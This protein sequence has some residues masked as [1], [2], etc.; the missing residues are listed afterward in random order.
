MEQPFSGSPAGLGAYTGPWET[1]QVVHL[2]KRT[3]FGAS[4]AD[5]NYF[6]G[7]SM[8]QAVDELLQPGAAP[9]TKP[10]N[11]YGTDPTGVAEWQTWIDQGLL[12]TDEEM[13]MN[14][15]G[16]L[17]A[18]WTGQMLGQGR[19][20]HEKMTLFWHN[21]FAM[22][23]TQHFG[24]IPA[25]LWYNQYLTLRKYALGSF[26]DLVR[27]ITLDPAMLIFL[28][29]STNF[30]TSPN[31][32]Y[33]RELQELYTIGK[34]SGSQYTQDDVV[35]AT[36]VLTGHT[37]DA[38]YKYIFLAG[39]H[40][41]KNKT[42]SAFYGNAIVTGRSGTPGASELDEMLAMLFAT[43]ESAK[44]ICR[45]LYNYFVYYK[46]DDMIETNV[47]DPLATIFRQS[48]YNISSVLS[49]LFKSQHFYDLV[50][51]GACIIKSPLDLLVGLCREYKVSIPDASNVAGQY[52]CWSMLSER[53]SILQQ[54]IMAI[55]LVAGWDAYRQSP[56]YHELWI[57]S[58]TY[59]GR[60]FYTDLLITTGDMMDGA[61]LQI[62]P[63]A[64]AKLLPSPHDP[65]LLI[66]DSLSV[67]I[68]PPMSENA[69]ALLKQSIL[70]GNLTN[71]LYWT[72]AWLG[73]IGDPTNMSA[74]SAVHGKLT[75]LYKYLM[76]L[77]EYHLS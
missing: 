73:Y 6:K 7:L 25:Q 26:T 67:L 29:G 10:L 54:E 59:T 72:N 50:N 43:Q 64:F 77:P 39:E 3:M 58:V 30:K 76:N 74:Y 66:S 69:I 42:F 61:T 63:V 5:I 40:D 65:N 1:S 13:N 55:P 70:L 20:I 45:K 49:A 36:H 33:G 32:N 16:S 23:A 8:S 27:A 4:V 56:Q 60:N 2:L 31:E 68:R 15:L 53:A 75:A 17:Q 62:D 11:N 44:F 47:I 12:Y 34:G 14:R 52:A 38:D 28:N 35:A 9:V 19:S 71:D 46:I 37:V 22:D 41:D 21:H 48:G 24:D 51:S 57:N 18:W